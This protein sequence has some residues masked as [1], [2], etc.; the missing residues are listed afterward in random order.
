[1]RHTKK[2]T[3]KKP[4]LLG[5]VGQELSINYKYPRK[6]ASLSVY[7]NGSK[8]TPTVPLIGAVEVEGD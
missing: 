3:K 8:G 4:F 1:V 5:M 6:A 7:I 2:D